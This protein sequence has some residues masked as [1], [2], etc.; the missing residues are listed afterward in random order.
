MTFEG[1]G[2]MH[3]HSL[4]QKNPGIRLPTYLLAARPLAHDQYRHPK[5]IPSN[6]KL[7]FCGMGFLLL[8]LNSVLPMLCFQVHPEPARVKCFASCH[9]LG[10]F[11]SVLSLE[12]GDGP[13]DAFT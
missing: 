11:S 1:K 8:I 4:D 5:G 12:T 13:N 6:V 7:A 10:R 9:V 2:G 3:S